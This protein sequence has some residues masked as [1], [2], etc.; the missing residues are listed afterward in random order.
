MEIDLT[1]IACPTWSDSTFSASSLNVIIPEKWFPGI[2]EKKLWS[3]EALKTEVL[4]GLA[5]VAKCMLSTRLA[6]IA[7]FFLDQL[8]W[9]ERINEHGVQLTI[10]KDERNPYE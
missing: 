4:W 7:S 6:A 1:H 2:G 3:I 8:F 5:T 9:I 10:A